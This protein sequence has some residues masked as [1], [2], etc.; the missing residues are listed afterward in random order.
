MIKLTN[1]WNWQTDQ[2]KTKLPVP[3][4]KEDITTDSTVIKKKIVL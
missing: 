1:F 4:I 3:V 2:E